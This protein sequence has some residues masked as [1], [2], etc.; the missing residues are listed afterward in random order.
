MLPE[1]DEVLL[2]RELSLFP[3]WYIARHLGV[4]LTDR[5]R[6]SLD[7]RAAS[8]PR[9][10]SRPAFPWGPIAITPARRVSRR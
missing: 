7:G 2:R 10:P 8:Q 3:D 4:T 9:R 1:Y 5:Q 6:A